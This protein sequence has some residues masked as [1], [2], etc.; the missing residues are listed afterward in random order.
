MMTRCDAKRAQQQYHFT[1]VALRFGAEL[2]LDLSQLA[3]PG[4]SGSP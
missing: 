4:K 3:A 2:G 1:G